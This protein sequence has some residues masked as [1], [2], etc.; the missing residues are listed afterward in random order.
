MD[1]LFIDI[2]I[3]ISLIIA[4]TDVLLSIM[5]FFKKK[6]TGR[7]LGAACIFAAIVDL[8]YL[9]SLMIDSYFYMSVLSSIYFVS[10]DIMLLCLLIFMVYFTKGSF[11]K[12]GITLIKI[13]F[14][15]AVFE[16]VIFTINPFNEI[17]LHYVYRDYIIA[18]YSY[19]MGI[20]YWM[21]LLYTYILVFTNIYLLLKKIFNTPKEYRTQYI[22][23]V[24][25][26]LLVV[27]IN[28][29]F[30]FFPKGTIYNLFD[31]SILCY[32]IVSFLLYWTCFNYSSH[33][34]LNSLKK[35]VFENIGQGIVLFDYNDNLI[36]FNQKAIELLGGIDSDECYHMD[37][38]IKCYD[39]GINIDNL[40]NDRISLQRVI[41]HNNVN[42]PI[43]YDFKRIRNSNGQITGQ[44]YVF[45]DAVLETDLLSGFQNW[46]SFVMYSS[47]NKKL[48]ENKV[49]VIIDIN[50]LSIIN[51]NFGINYGNEQIRNLAILMRDKFPKDAYFIRGL[52]ANLLAIVN[53]NELEV[54]NCIS[55]IRKE[56]DG[57]FQWAMS[58]VNNDDI[59]KVIAKV[60]AAMKSKKL[61]DKESIHS[62]MLTS[63]IRALEECDSDTELHVKRTQALGNS[64][65]KRIGLNDIELSHLSLLCL[66]H[67]IGKIGIPLEILNKPGKLTVEEWNILKTHAIKGYEIAKSNSELKVIATEIRHHHER[68]DGNGYPDGLSG[69]EIPMLSRVI[70]VVDAY[71]AMTNN[72][73]YRKAMSP[74]MAINELLSCSGTQ[75]DPMIVN[76]FV[77]MLE[78]D[79]EPDQNDSVNHTIELSKDKIANGMIHP[80][81][82]ARYILDANNYIVDVDDS[83]VKMTGYSLDYIKR[84]KMKQIDII[85]EDDRAEYELDVRKELSE[86]P[87][88]LLEHRILCRDG[89]I[90]TVLC[91][92]RLYY[93][94]A[95]RGE[96]SE[97]II[98]DI[99]KTYSM[100][101]VSD[102]IEK[103]AQIQLTNYERMFQ[104]DSLTG[105]LNHNSF[106]KEV[107]KKL[108]SKRTKTMMIMADLDHFKYYNDSYG[109]Y[110]GDKFLILAA[111]AIQSTLRIDDNAC[112]MG[113]DEFAIAISFSNDVKDEQIKERALQIFDKVSFILKTTDESASISMGA[114]IA[115]DHMSFNQL[116]EL[117]DKA[118]YNA[119]ND[120]RNKIEI[121]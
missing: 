41:R 39:L 6:S 5:C 105:L 22:F 11:R 2:Y 94:S 86:N 66:L 75:F 45:T 108:N 30:L 100:R 28:A 56:Y 98:V 55:V 25:G 95:I 72:R 109:H 65:G 120:G 80:V 1:R 103:K 73:S 48:F 116:Y 67:D 81:P 104:Y 23:A 57:K 14:L 27:F 106:K 19:D 117:S 111:Q 3:N 77:R 60:T 29:L 51:S 40:T 47:G 7:Y 63:L 70:S 44:L 68:W 93:D 96:R 31:Y 17:V 10:I 79:G 26:I 89:R 92:G 38:F 115:K 18:S 37:D 113:G 52:E 24:V 99:R 102:E 90:M 119:K 46:D 71:D 78:I 112:R 85:V 49:V 20:L 91:I 110:N 88:V 64:L 97:I 12:Y 8:S 59:L 16:I 21:H 69:E 50:S 58:K 87:L 33:G 32:S 43:R 35:N 13:A 54:E 61:L 121:M 84:H 76:E 9:G 118:L 62:D 114:A 4:L 101:I 107:E 36:L 83:F 42:R 34:M 53:A 15:Y 74:N 82:Y